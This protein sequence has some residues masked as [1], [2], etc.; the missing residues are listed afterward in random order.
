MGS[1][2][3]AATCAFGTTVTAITTDYGTEVNLVGLPVYRFSEF[4]P[5]FCDLGF[6]ADAGVQVEAVEADP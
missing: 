1:S 4:F 5:Y 2:S 3:P 6:I